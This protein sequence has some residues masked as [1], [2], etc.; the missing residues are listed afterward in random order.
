M[1]KENRTFAVIGLGAFGSAVAQ[2]LAREDNHVLGIDLDE[3]RVAQ[4]APTLAAAGRARAAGFTWDRSTAALA[5]G[6]RAA[7]GVGETA[8]R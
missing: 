1:A 8:P 4:M 5:A 2:E 7:A 3:K 6:Y